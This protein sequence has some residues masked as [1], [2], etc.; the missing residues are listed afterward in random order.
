MLVLV[1]FLVLFCH[2]FYSLIHRFRLK[3][4]SCIVNGGCKNGSFFMAQNHDVGSLTKHIYVTYCFVNEHICHVCIAVEYIHSTD[5]HA[6]M[7]TKNLSE[8]DHLKHATAIHAG[9]VSVGTWEDF[10]TDDSQP[11][12]MS[13]FFFVLDD[14]AVRFGT[15][16]DVD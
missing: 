1:L 10:S 14:F 4:L 5:N 8:S 16:E 13:T 15:Q 11:N 6:D 12:A 2:F 3:L 7:L 9:L